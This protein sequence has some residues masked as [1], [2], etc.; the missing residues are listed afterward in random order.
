MGISRIETPSGYGA[1]ARTETQR[2]LLVSFSGIDGAGKTT[3]IEKL[4]SWL[5]SA[6]LRVCLIRFW[7]D[8]A[9]LRLVREASGRILFKGEGGVGAP[10]KPVRRRDKNVQSRAMLLVRVGLCLLD[11]LS[12]TVMLARA[13]RWKHADVIVFDRYLYD[14]FANLDTQNRLLCAYIQVLL[15]L[16]PRPDVAYLLDADPVAARE[17]KPEYPIEFLHGNR[18]RYFAI[19]A[20]A[21]LRA[22]P[23][24]SPEDVGSRV[25][26]ELEK[27]LGRVL[28][29]SYPEVST[30]MSG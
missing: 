2:P 10:G 3:Q 9:A 28:D 8:V 22:I 17:R 29:S 16:A 27:K 12:L 1:Q 20:I 13:R 23:P 4:I 30:S 25:R 19:A 5:R 7:D 18:D 21:G 26:S 6:G 24:G 14:Q 15:R 11:S